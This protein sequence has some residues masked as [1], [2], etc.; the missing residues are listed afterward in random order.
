LSQIWSDF[1]LLAF[2]RRCETLRLQGVGW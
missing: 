1:A 2:R